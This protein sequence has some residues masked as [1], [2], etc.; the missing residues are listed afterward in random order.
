M[1]TL[2][3]PNSEFLTIDSAAELLE[4]SPWTVR[5]AINRGDIRAYRFK[6]TRVIRIKRSDLDKALK[7]V[8]TVAENLGGDAA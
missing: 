2:S 7:P 5:R 4:C 6:K 8:T 3:Q 1:A